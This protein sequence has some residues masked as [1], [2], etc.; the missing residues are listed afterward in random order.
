MIGLV[1]L[2]ISI[3][4]A[5]SGLMSKLFDKIPAAVAKRFQGRFFTIL[6]CESLLPSLSLNSDCYYFNRLLLQ[7]EK[8][9]SMYE[10][11]EGMLEP[12]RERRFSVLKVGTTLL[13]LDESSKKGISQ[14][15][16]GSLEDKLSISR[17]PDEEVEDDDSTIA[18]I[19]WSV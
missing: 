2:S 3:G 8:K 10:L 19:S 1:F 14:G 5:T 15:S 9:G 16:I 4:D 7:E 11:I 12:A 6:K 18:D 17:N 13:A